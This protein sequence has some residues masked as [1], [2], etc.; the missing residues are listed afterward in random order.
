MEDDVRSFVLRT[1]EEREIRFIRLWFTDVLGF[2]K[3]FAIP[4]EE[5]DV[6]LEEGVGFDGSAIDG[7]ARVQ[8]ADMVAHPDPST[9]QILPWRPGM[10]GVAR[11]F[12]NI[13]TPENVLFEG[14]PRA[15]LRRALDRATALGFSFY[16]G[17]EIEFFLFRNATLPEPLDVGTY[18]DL[19][20]LDVGSDFRRRVIAYLEHFG[21][22][23]K[24]SHHAIAA[25]QHEVDLRH[26]DAL[27]MADSVMT[28]RL[29]VK[30]VAQELDVYATFMP[31]PIQ[32]ADGSSM[33][34][35]MSLFEGD[36]NA[37]FDATDPYYLSKTARSFVAGLLRHAREISAVTNQWVNSYKRLVPGFEAPLYLCWGVR[38]RSALVRVPLTKPGKEAACR[39]EYR[40]PDP[41]CNPYLAFAL[42]LSA[43][44]RGVEHEYELPTEAANDIY[45]MSEA[46]RSD[47]GIEPLPES[48]PEAIAEMQRSELVREA[49]GEHLFEWFIANKK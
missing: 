7:F 41:A 39:I 17:T 46:E 24:D 45:A 34:T 5:L 1:A 48:L 29:A 42:I 36:R 11:M 25:S 22:P 49:L 28:F 30:E 12:C 20:P 14:D 32:G 35:H 26:T 4:V 16:I 13:R 8:E 38:N 37:F 31:K 2:L 6:A 10:S 19:T 33:H 47:L 23:V 44:L 18:F 27:T 9:F 43:G 15:V 40:A 3:S 21:V